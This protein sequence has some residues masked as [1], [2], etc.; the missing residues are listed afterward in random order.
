ME[1]WFVLEYYLRPAVADDAENICQVLI[2]SVR[3]ICAPD[4]GNDIELLNFWCSDKT[5]ENLVS[6][7]ADPENY[8]VVAVNK[9]FKRIVGAGLIKNSGNLQICY[10]VPE[11]IGKGVGKLMLTKMLDFARGRGLKKVKVGSTITAK[12]FYEKNGFVVIK[13]RLDSRIPQIDMELIL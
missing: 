6:W 10:L 8:F 2:R 5:P 1:E 7:I 9:K 13:E 3:E 11:A 12:S 4:Y